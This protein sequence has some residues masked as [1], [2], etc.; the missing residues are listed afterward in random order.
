MTI[1][2]RRQYIYDKAHAELENDDE[3][4]CEACE[5]LDSWDGFLGDDR[6]YYMSEIDELLY[7][8]KPSEIINMMTSDFNANDD[9]FYF[10]I[11]G[12]ESCNDRWEH[13]SDLYTVDDVLDKLIEEYNHVSLTQNATLDSLVEM[14][15]EENFGIEDEEDPDSEDNTTD[16]EFMEE[17]DAL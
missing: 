11:Y 12:L 13:Y 10:S 6:C 16:E 3:V 14:L 1:E 5:K 17:V 2:E 15:F 8:K 7:G 4:F 9:F